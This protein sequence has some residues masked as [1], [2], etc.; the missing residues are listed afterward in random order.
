M[1]DDAYADPEQQFQSPEI[2]G[3]SPVIV[4]LRA[5]VARLLS[6]QVAGGRLP[7]ILLEGETGTGKGLMA[8]ALHRCSMRS[9]KPFIDVDCAAIPEPLLESEMFGYERGAFTDARQTKPGLFQLADRGT[10]FLD[11]IGLLPRSLQAKLLK[12]VED[13]GVRRLGGTRSQ[14]V[15]VWIITATNEDLAAATR[16]RLFREDLYHRL[17]A[18]TLRMPPLRERGADIVLLAERFLARVS[19]EYGLPTK[20]LTADAKAAILSHPWP[21]NVRELLNVIERVVLLSDEPIITADRLELSPCLQ[22]NGSP[23]PAS[24][25]MPPRIR[26]F[27]RIVDRGRLVEVLAE[28]DWNLSLAAAR[29]AVPRN[30]LRYWMVKLEVHP[31]GGA[32]PVTASRPRDLPA[33]G[34]PSGAARNGSTSNSFLLPETKLSRDAGPR[35]RI[36]REGCP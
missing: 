6:R 4:R 28:A 8:R 19:T 30:T 16:G 33:A 11:E 7:P 34:L 21:G 31:S 10:I 22:P 2:I 3:N 5:Q 25:E 9:A 17:A 24:P 13:R 18:L 23:P 1:N 20:M 15:D 27:G 36:R 12:V 35:W 14:I 32:A 26:R 29:L